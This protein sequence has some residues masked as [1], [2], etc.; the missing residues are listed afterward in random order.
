MWAADE[1]NY[2]KESHRWDHRHPNS[3][4]RNPIIT[5]GGSKLRKRWYNICYDLLLHGVLNPS[6]LLLQFIKFLR[7]ALPNCGLR[8][9]FGFKVDHFCYQ[10]PNCLNIVPLQPQVQLADA[11]SLVEPEVELEEKLGQPLEHLA[12]GGYLEPLFRF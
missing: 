4:A 1:R 9:F 12:V 11:R 5:T 8:V 2:N 3:G 6:I 7:N 10:L